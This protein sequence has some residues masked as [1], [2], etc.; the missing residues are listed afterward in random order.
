[1]LADDNCLLCQGQE[2]RQHLFFG[3]PFSSIVWR[4]LLHNLKEYH[5]P[6]TW[7]AEA[8]W[9][10]NKGMDK[11][12]GERL[13]RMCAA[14]AIYYIW[15]ERNRRIFYDT[16]QEAEVVAVKFVYAVR[17]SVNNWRGIA[18]NKANWK[19]YID[20]GFDFAIFDKR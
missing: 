12:F 13:R 11:S 16:R 5:V 8:E 19:I 20:W 2:T 17:C 3:I 7:E 14:A 1:M 4:K 18:R 9:F 6:Q 10:M 15:L